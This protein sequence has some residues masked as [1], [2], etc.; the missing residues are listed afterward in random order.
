MK[1]KSILAAVAFMAAGSAGATVLNFDGLTERM[2]GDGFP[3]AASMTYNGPNL[4]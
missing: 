1:F 2:Y 3:L 4:T